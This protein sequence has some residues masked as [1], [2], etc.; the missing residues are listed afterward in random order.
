[1]LDLIKEHLGEKAWEATIEWQASQERKLIEHQKATIKN[2]GPVEI[3]FWKM[4]VPYTGTIGGHFSYKFTP[5]SI[6]LFCTVYD[7]IQKEELHLTEYVD[8]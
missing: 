2:P 5:S 1:M 3:S 4:D 6:G 7:E 8:Y